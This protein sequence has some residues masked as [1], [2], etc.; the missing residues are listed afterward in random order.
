MRE[1]LFVLENILI[2]TWHLKV[3]RGEQYTFYTYRWFDEK[4][5]L[6]ASTC[7]LF[8]NVNLGISE[9]SSIRHFSTKLRGCLYGGGPAL[10]RA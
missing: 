5:L 8:K 3:L 4:K 7:C 1:L 2:S 6:G 9:N 10:G